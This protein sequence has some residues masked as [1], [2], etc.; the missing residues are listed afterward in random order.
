[1]REE[2]SG[3]VASEGVRA[4]EAAACLVC[5]L[6]ECIQDPVNELLLETGVHISS[7]QSTHDLQDRHQHITHT[8][9]KV[10]TARRH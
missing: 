7:P 6:L 1:M 10:C 2:W 9:I 5:L 4:R 8:H 3:V